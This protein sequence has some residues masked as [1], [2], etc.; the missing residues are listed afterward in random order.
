VSPQTRTVFL[1]S[2]YFS[3][4]NTRRTAQN[5]GLHS[6]A[7]L[8]FGKGLDPEGPPAALDRMA[9]LLAKIGA[10]RTAA[11]IID[12]YPRPL[13]ESKVWMLEVPVNIILG[14]DLGSDQVD[15]LLERHSVEI[16]KQ[17]GGV[18]QLGVSAYRQDVE[19]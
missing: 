11:G 5:L 14:L 13:P 15:D 19:T 18:F 4:V 2:A 6:E 17:R 9:H 7:A 1:E 3:P 8:R 12:R 16:S 10:G